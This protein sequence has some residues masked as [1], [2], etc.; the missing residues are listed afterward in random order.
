MVSVEPQEP[1]QHVQGVHLVAVEL[2]LLAD[3]ADAAGALPVAVD[4]AHH[5]RGLREE[6]LWAVQQ[7]PAR[8]HL[9]H[10]ACLARYRSYKSIL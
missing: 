5:P 4:G 7:T 9:L 10:G 3:A 1:A 2:A 8:L 6:S